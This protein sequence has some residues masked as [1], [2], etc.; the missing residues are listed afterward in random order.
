[1]KRDTERK[2]ERKSTAY[3]STVFKIKEV[4]IIYTK[5]AMEVVSMFNWASRCKDKGLMQTWSWYDR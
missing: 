1:M 2:E 3:I 4:D 5:H